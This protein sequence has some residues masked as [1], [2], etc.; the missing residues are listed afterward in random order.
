MTD[1]T[2]EPADRREP[3]DLQDEIQK[4][5][6]DYAMSVIVGRA[7]PGARGG[8]KPVHRR[9][10]Y[11][12]FDG[13]Y[14]P[15]RG[16][17]KCARV[18]GEVMGQYH[19][20]GDGAIYDTLVRLAQPWVMRYPL[21]AG[22]GNFGSPGND[23]AAAMRYTEGRM[24]PLAMEMGPDLPEST[25]DFTPNHD[26]KEQEATVVPADAPNLAGQR[27]GANPG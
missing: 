24:A 11:A 2:N 21:V 8:L 15:D 20:H 18:V 26:G 17:N 23:K 19:P 1:V 5:Y 9:I 22:Q 7:L 12:M 13:G 27:A 25:Q 16:W 10:L 4:A 6:L 14:R 3:V